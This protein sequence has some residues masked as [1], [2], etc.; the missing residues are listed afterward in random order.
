MDVV[1]QG[2]R[3][4]ITRESVEC[5]RDEPPGTAQRYVVCLRGVDYPL[6]QAASAGLGVPP[7]AFTSQQAYRWLVKLGF[8]V[9]DL[10][11]Q[12]TS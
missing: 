9:L 7:V 1:L 10:R 4:S 3:F 5:V 12:G 6:K 2:K 11:Q 8:E